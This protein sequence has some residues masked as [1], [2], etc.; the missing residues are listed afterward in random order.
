MQ[1]VDIGEMQTNESMDAHHRQVRGC[2]V[3][4]V[5]AGQNRRRL[6]NA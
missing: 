3:G 2:A 1:N 4:G 5:Y 6:I